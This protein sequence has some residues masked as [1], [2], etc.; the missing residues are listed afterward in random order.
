M[1][2]DLPEMLKQRPK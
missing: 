2:F 1:Q